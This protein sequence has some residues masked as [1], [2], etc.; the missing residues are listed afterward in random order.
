MSVRDYLDEVA[1]PTPSATGGV[2]GAVTVAA[3]A[4][5][6][7]MT[8][9]LRRDSTRAAQ[10]EALRQR[11]TELAVADSDAYQAVLAAQRRDADDPDRAAEL[12]DAMSAAAAPPAAL[13]ALAEQVAVL[14]A[15]VAADATPALRGD[16]LTAAALAAA[17]A[18]G[19]AILVRINLI[20]AD[21]D[22][23]AADAADAHAAEAARHSPS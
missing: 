5:L 18:R 6:T 13:A 19:A 2:V 17:A 9:R 1:A 11:A 12:A 10:A 15:E 4:G 23:G 3:A 14:A 20:A 21:A 16:A 7:A 22:L 8:A